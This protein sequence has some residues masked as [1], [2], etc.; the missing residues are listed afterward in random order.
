[1]AFLQITTDD[2][3]KAG[4]D[5]MPMCSDL[6][7]AVAARK[8]SEEVGA[9]IAREEAKELGTVPDDSYDA[10]EMPDSALKL[11]GVTAE[12]VRI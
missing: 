8:Y 5:K 9:A 11:L 6:T 10:A 7:D 2:D 12:E 1:M 4:S 3:A